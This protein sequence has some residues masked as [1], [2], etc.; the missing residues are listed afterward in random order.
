MGRM[1]FAGEELAA[2]NLLCTLDFAQEESEEARGGKGNT[3][4]RPHGHPH[5]LRP[6]PP[7]PSLSVSRSRDVPSVRLGGERDSSRRQ[8]DRKQQSRGKKAGRG[9][10]AGLHSHPLSACRESCPVCAQ[11]IDSDSKP[12]EVL[13][14]C[15]DDGGCGPAVQGRDQR[16]DG[17]H[18][19]N[20]EVKASPPG[21]QPE[22]ALPVQAACSPSLRPR[23]SLR[24][25][26][27]AVSLPP[28]LSPTV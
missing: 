6:R 15:A 25:A 17:S 10:R 14:R 16:R 23:Q 12:A 3:S 4:R 26:E 19:P 28:C 7:L 13:G 20:E 22:L 24:T 27:R 18:T 2:A 5:P 11:D 1:A 8:Q 21:P 9:G